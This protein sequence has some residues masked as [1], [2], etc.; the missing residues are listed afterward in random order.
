MD[1]NKNYWMD[2]T[3][4][5]KNL[6]FTLKSHNFDWSLNERK[7]GPSSHYEMHEWK[8]NRRE[9]ELMSLLNKRKEKNPWTTEN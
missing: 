9:K 8:R 5:V 7:H 3:K 1:L 2:G 6:Y 4:A